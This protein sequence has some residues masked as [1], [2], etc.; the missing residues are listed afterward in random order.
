MKFTKPNVDLGYFWDTNVWTF[1][2]WVH[3]DGVG[4]APGTPPRSSP[5]LWG[6]GGGAG[7]HWKGGTPPPPPS[8]AS[9]CQQVPASMAF[10]TDRSTPTALATSSKRLSNCFWGCL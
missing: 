3:S 9:P 5:P 8:R 6:R 1:G 4:G 10:V 7:M 2:F